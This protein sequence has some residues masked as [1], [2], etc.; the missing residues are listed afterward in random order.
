MK[1][2]TILTVKGHEVASIRPDAPVRDLV[3]QL[4]EHNYGALVVSADGATVAG[5][6]SERD[7]VR[8][9]STRGAAVLDEPVSTIMTNVVQCAP[10][11]AAVEDIMALMTNRRVRHIP[12]VDESGG[13]IGLVSIGDVVKNRLGELQGERDALMQYV[14]SS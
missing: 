13:M 5:M 4:A 10:P 1:L 8:A 2:E 14:T 12:V 11:D 6:A 9:L 3:V 7:I